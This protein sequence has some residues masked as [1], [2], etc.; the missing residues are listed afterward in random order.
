MHQAKPRKKN[1]S[2]ILYGLF[3]LYMRENGSKYNRLYNCEPL[4]FRL[5]S[6]GK[7]ED[8]K[9]PSFMKYSFL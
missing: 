5:F 8:M 3:A 7:S 1:E 4:G 9:Y 6:R 2:L